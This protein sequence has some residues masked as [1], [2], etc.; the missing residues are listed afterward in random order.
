MKYGETRNEEIYKKGIQKNDKV[1]QRGETCLNAH[2]GKKL[3][4]SYAWGGGKI[5]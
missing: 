5:P 1:R 2:S 3:D 4:K